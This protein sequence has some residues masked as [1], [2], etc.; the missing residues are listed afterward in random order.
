MYPTT[1]VEG[2]LFQE[3]A[4]LCW[5]AGVPVP[6]RDCR[7][8]E[9]DALLANDALAEA[10][11]L[12]WGANLT[13]KDTL[14]PA[15]KVSGRDNPLTVNSEVLRLASV[16]VMLELLAVN[17]AVRLLLCPT[18]TLP[19]LNAAGLT[20]NWPE[21]VA[22]PTIE[23]V[24][25][26]LE[27]S[28]TTAID[29]LALPPEVGANTAPKVKLCPGLKVR[30][31]LKPVILKLAPVML[32]RVTVTLEPPELVRV[33]D[34][35]FVLPTGTPEKSR[36]ESLVLSA[37]PVATLAET[38]MTRLALEASLTIERLPLA[39]PLERG[40]KVRLRAVL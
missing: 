11:P 4:T 23:M 32:A 37:P 31:R 33:S 22:V 5:G 3:R 9:L 38:G 16:M 10:A 27:A 20:A 40:V 7:R 26:G 24:T 12:D 15:A 30:G 13:V 39:D 35:V 19:K 14:L 28:E 2:L 34:K 17:E 18:T 21:T 36:L 8:E 6:A 29:P 25:V 1:V